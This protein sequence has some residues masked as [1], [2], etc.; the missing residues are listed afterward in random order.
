[1]D[2]QNE[3]KSPIIYDGSTRVYAMKLLEGD[4]TFGLRT[5][6]K[7][8]YAQYFTG[9]PGII[10]V[11]SAVV[12]T[13]PEVMAT[14]KAILSSGCCRMLGRA[15]ACRAVFLHACSAGTYIDTEI[16]FSTFVPEADNPFVLILQDVIRSV[17]NGE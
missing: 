2:I 1:M 11:G 4:Y 3:L 9:E 13:T 14:L 15:D 16:L 10:K 6:F 8:Y 7:E 17:L 5:T 12:K